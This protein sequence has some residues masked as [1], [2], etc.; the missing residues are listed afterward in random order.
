MESTNVILESVENINR[1]VED[2]ELDTVMALTEAYAKMYAVLESC[3]SNADLSEFSIFQE[4]VKQ[5]G[6]A[7]K[8]KGPDTKFDKAFNA[9]NQ[10]PLGDAKINRES[11]TKKILLFI[12][13][14]IAT[15]LRIAL[16][17]IKLIGD[18]IVMAFR[19]LQN[20]IDAKQR[21]KDRK[22]IISLPFNADFVFETVGNIADLV[23]DVCDYM[24]AAFQFTTTNPE[25]QKH[26]VA[27]SIVDAMKQDMAIVSKIKTSIRDWD[28]EA[29]T[30]NSI[31]RAD[32]KLYIKTIKNC[33]KTI[34]TGMK[35]I[36]K[37]DND[38]EAAD[39]KLDKYD[40]QR[41]TEFYRIMGQWSSK[42]TELTKRLKKLS[43]DAKK[44]QTQ[45]R[46]DVDD[47]DVF[48]DGKPE[49]FDPGEFGDGFVS[50]PDYSQAA[51]NNN[52]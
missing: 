22:E 11:L 15:G 18:Y 31:N 19:N 21:E 48:W 52:V 37:Y 2:A 5:F 36:Q 47:D 26:A 20:N 45:E 8:V 34:Q 49:P 40:I 29:Y 39:A 17:V 30:T 10:S 3:D 9:I 51:W 32:A 16:Q 24:Q 23:E 13:R 41:V 1:S 33:Q 27:H 12:P 14:L 50:E 4:G 42:G 6:G 44:A 28:N 38:P 43:K 46:V 35:A 7:I 25:D